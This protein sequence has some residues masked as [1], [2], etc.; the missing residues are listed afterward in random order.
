MGRSAGKSVL[1]AS[2]E[3]CVQVHR[4]RRFLSP[5]SRVSLIAIAL[6]ASATALRATDFRR[7]DSNSDSAVSISDAHHTMSYLFRGGSPAE[8]ESSADSNDDGKMDIADGLWILNFL[9]RGGPPPNE[10]SPG[11]GP[12]PTP[13][14]LG[15]ASYGSSSPLSDPAARLTVLDTTAQGGADGRVAIRIAV[16]NSASIA[17]YSGSIAFDGPIG[18]IDRAPTD[19]SGTLH[20]G[21]ATSDLMT[22]PEGLR[23]SFGFLSTLTDVQFI[24][25]GS[26]AVVLEMVG[27]L[28][29][30]T[31][32][33]EYPLLLQA[34]ELVD[35]DSGRSIIPV[36][37][38]GMLTV[39]ADLSAEAGCPDPSGGEIGACSEYPYPDPLP[40][41]DAVFRMDSDS[42]LPGS[43]V[44]VPF[45]IFAT[46]VTQG[47]AFSV[48]FDEDVLEVTQIEEVF[49]AKPKPDGFSVLF[50][51]NSR[52]TPGSGLDEG[53]MVGAA[54]FNFRGPCGNLPADEYTEV[55][56][57][58]FA[59]R[60]GAPTGSTDV[61]F[62]DGA[63]GTGQPVRNTLTTLG[64]AFYPETESTF[65][66]VNARI[67]VLPDLTAFVRGDS[68]GDQKVD[69]SDAANTLGYLFLGDTRVACFDAADANDDGAIDIADAV[70]TLNHLFEGGEEL[71]PPYPAIGED[72]TS[73]TL[74]CLTRH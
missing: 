51:D 23:L 11:I 42:G 13:D 27:C 5:V 7:A 58:H 18:N 22:T 62:K 12:D 64:H 6:A 21:F 32:A 41:V 25:A 55:L 17:G 34:G 39:L 47:Y 45:K 3:V 68:N 4:D 46:E 29:E 48:D 31:L 61:M 15:C 57:F 49:K 19:L 26:N 2:Q 71:P 36:L 38:S 20:A 16:S 37:E 30:G 63:R 74:G 65:V 56:R 10:P 73:D 44:V 28:A 50:Y 67:N 52:N 69:I 54:V 1:T 43:D 59:I 66:L 9:F 40:Q 33:G 60:P 53:V 24:P 35:A 72:P 14:S 8:C 70:T